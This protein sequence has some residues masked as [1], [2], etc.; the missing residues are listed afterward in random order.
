MYK[1]IYIYL[2]AW[3]NFE[4]N[5]RNTKSVWENTDMFRY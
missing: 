4:I 2:Y 1:Y 5:L 3:L